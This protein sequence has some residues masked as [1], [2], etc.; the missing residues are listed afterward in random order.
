MGHVVAEPEIL[1][2]P[3]PSAALEPRILRRKSSYQPAASPQEILGVWPRTPPLFRA[4]E[5]PIFSGWGFLRRRWVAQAAT[6]SL[7]VI[8]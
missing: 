6:S 2:A 4:R 3:M 5:I 7:I 8:G 1:A